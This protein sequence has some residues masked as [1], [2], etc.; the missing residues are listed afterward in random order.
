MSKIRVALLL[1]IGVLLPGIASFASGIPSATVNSIKDYAIINSPAPSTPPELRDVWL[2]FHKH[3]LCEKVDAAFLF[4]KDEMEIVVETG[5]AKSNRKLL[6]MLE[7]LHDSYPIKLHT[8]ELQTEREFIDIRN[9]PPSFWL[10]SKLTGYLRDSFLRNTSAFYFESQAQSSDFSSSIM[11]GKRMLLF[12]RDTLDYNRKMKLYA[13]HLPSL[14]RAAV[15]PNATPDLRKQALEICRAHIKKLEKYTKKLNGNLTM[16]VPKAAP[17]SQKTAQPEAI[18][19]ANGSSV[20]IAVQLA[21]EAEDLSRRVY[22]FIYPQSHTVEVTDLLNPSILQSL[23][24]LQNTTAK[25]QNSI[26]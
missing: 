5:N 21:D 6:E 17:K 7:S 10:N 4:H 19:A 11:F 23:K 3:N 14:A 24:N 2:R 8:V 15:D 1:S 12:A 22:R 9:P 25:L 20:G 18:M 13:S 16:A 26:D